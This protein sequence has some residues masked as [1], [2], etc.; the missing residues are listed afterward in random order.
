MLIAPRVAHKIFHHNRVT[1]TK[2]TSRYLRKR[3]H[4]DRDTDDVG[5]GS[6]NDNDDG[7]EREPPQKRQRRSDEE[8]GR[9]IAEKV[10]KALE[11]IRAAPGNEQQPTD[12]IIVWVNRFYSLCMRHILRSKRQ[13]PRDP[14]KDQAAEA[15]QTINL[16][17]NRIS[18]LRTNG[19]V[20]C[21]CAMSLYAAFAS[22]EFT[23][24][25][26]PLRT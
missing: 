13:L 12:R 26:A 4:V 9:C 17:V 18:A 19:G 5:D 10:Q 6:D 2:A 16:V 25:S 15:M 22:K 14:K 7:A 24:P 8:V 23:L 1:N 20:T 3:N 21:L 11:E